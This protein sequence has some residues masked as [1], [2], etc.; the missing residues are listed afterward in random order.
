MWTLADL[1]TPAHPLAV[2]DKWTLPFMIGFHGL[3]A[4]M[5]L[6]I[7]AC[8]IALL[9]N[10]T[11]TPK[12]P[13]GWGSVDYDANQI[14]RLSLANYCSTN[15]IDVSTPMIQFSVATANF[16]GIFTEDTA[17]LAPWHGT[18]SREAARLQVE[19]GA[20]AI[21]LDI[22]PDPANP[23]IPIVAAMLDTYQNTSMA[24][25]R[26]H[27]LD[28]GVG[29][30]SNWQRLT[31]NTAP[32]GEILAAAAEAHDPAVADGNGTQLPQVRHQDRVH[33][34]FV[35]QVQVEVLK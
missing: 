1:I 13:V 8:I 19:A 10:T 26:N 6:I 12:Q 21:V 29:R 5:V 32:A 11:K 17:L 24:W 25:W 2:S 7:F 15:N 28:K 27:G 3:L 18:V 14:N 23:A 16:G 34:G 30:Y 20:R 9:V 33:P 35:L 4:F 22:W 31:R